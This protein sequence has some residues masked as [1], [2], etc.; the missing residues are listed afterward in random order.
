MHI[1]SPKISDFLKFIL[2]FFFAVKALAVEQLL[3]QIIAVPWTG[4]VQL[5]K[6]QCRVQMALEIKSL[7]FL[8]VADA[9][10]YL[11]VILICIDLY[12]KI[13]QSGIEYNI[14]GTD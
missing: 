13:T 3:K 14:Y 11:G 8:F 12:L 4:S 10:S 1:W 6:I 9:M 2:F 5:A 7:H